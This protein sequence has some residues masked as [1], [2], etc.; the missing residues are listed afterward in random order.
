MTSTGKAIESHSLERLLMR[1]RAEQACIPMQKCS[2]G[3]G[4]PVITRRRE[5]RWQ[6][7]TVL[8]LN[9]NSKALMEVGGSADWFPPRQQCYLPPLYL[10]AQFWDVLHFLEKQGMGKAELFPWLAGEFNLPSPHSGAGGSSC[11]QE[12]QSQSLTPSRPAPAHLTATQGL[13][14]QAGPQEHEAPSA[15]GGEELWVGMTS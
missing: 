15:P 4:S 5:G 1:S 11:S 12:P 13:A 3:M 8:S 9:R 14:R 10:E 2:Q 6:Q 7:S